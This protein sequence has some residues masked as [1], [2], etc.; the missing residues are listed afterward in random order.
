MIKKTILVWILTITLLS[1]SWV[2]AQQPLDEILEEILGDTI[3]IEEKIEQEAEVEIMDKAIDENIIDEDINNDTL[4]K[5]ATIWEAHNTAADILEQLDDDQWTYVDNKDAIAEVSKTEK[6]SI[7]LQTTKALYDG[8]DVFSYKVFYSESMLSSQK[9]SDIESVI[10]RWK[11]AS[12]GK[13]VELILD[14]LKTNTTYYAVIAP[15][16]PDDEWD[17]PLEKITWEIKFK[18]N[19]DVEDT[20][21]P[22]WDNAWSP[23]NNEPQAKNNPV[24]LKNIKNSIENNNVELSRLIENNDKHK[25][26]ISLRHNNDISFSPVGN[27]NADTQKFSFSVDKPGPYF[28]KMKLMDSSWKQVWA[29]KN[30]NINVAAFDEDITPIVTNPPK[31]WPATDI[32][33]ALILFAMMIYIVYR[34]RRVESD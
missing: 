34:V 31:V 17:A 32:M 28:V 14:G 23:A 16:N 15:V 12:N 8:K 18:T 30:I 11:N 21:E 5:D 29:D 4:N 3:D 10:I 25:I 33:I 7:I 6:N 2:S 24:N 22:I 27:I 13:K 1:L 26:D 20:N 9:F 19:A